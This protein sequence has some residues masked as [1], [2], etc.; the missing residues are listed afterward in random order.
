MGIEGSEREHVRAAARVRLWH[1]R[2]EKL[3]QARREAAPI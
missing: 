2:E 3:V 1:R